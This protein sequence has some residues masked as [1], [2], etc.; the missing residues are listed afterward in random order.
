MKKSLKLF[1]LNI[2]FILIFIQNF[3]NYPKLIKQPFYLFKNYKLSKL[4]NFKINKNEN[5]IL[6]NLTNLKYSYNYKYN[7]VQVIYNIIFFDEYNNII[8]PSDLTL[9]NNL[10]II[11]Y[12]KSK[13]SKIYSLAYVIE[14]K[15]YECIEYIGINQKAIFGIKIF[16]NKN[17]YLTI[18]FFKNDIIIYKK[19]NENKKLNSIVI[20]M[21]YQKL[22]ENIR[23]NQSKSLKLKNLY[24]N[25][26]TYLKKDN[27]I[28]KSNTWYFKNI[29]NSYF[30]F[31][32]DTCLYSNISQK[33]KYLFYLYIIDNNRELYNKTDFLMSDFYYANK[34]SDDTYPIFREMIKQNLSAHYMDEKKNLYSKYCN[35]EKH[36]LKII[37]VVNRYIFIDGDFLEKYLDLILKLKAVIT[38]DHFYSYDNIFYNIDYISY[39]NL[40]HGVKYFKHYLYNDYSSYKKYNKLILPPSKKIILLAKKYGWSDNNIIKTC[41]PKWDKYDSYKKD[42]ILKN[43]NLK[44]EKYIFAMF[45]WRNLK[46]AQYNISSFYFKGIIELINNNLL[47]EILKKNNIILYFTLHHNFINYKNKFKINKSIKFIN[48]TQISDCLTKSNLLIS[49]FSSIIFEMIYQKKPYIMYIPD[50][51]DSNIKY[52]YD[53]GYFD[54]INGLKNDSIYFKNKFFNINGTINKIIYYINNNFTLELNLKK[55]YDSFEFKCKNNTQNLINYLVNIN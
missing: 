5:E 4:S 49:D 47:K 12:M 24:I 53:N 41:L 20:S 32:K 16:S 37:P 10:N 6:F 17:E 3:I 19:N 40:G 43:I 45:T 18:Y 2:I 7:V 54:I 29:Y 8:K 25:M 21:E 26:P 9:F 23:N 42:L 46:D 11:C 27:C 48:H 44:N 30:C 1:L 22:F 52:I 13:K 14:N 36:C 15:Q 55:F 39:I 38:G 28:Y 33:C 34:S 35:Y 50:A 51:L 31:C